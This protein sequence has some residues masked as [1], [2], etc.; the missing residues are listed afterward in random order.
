MDIKE[1]LI[2][3]EI[4]S[5]PNSKLAQAYRMGRRDVHEEYNKLLKD[6]PQDTLTLEGVR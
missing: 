5:Y 4:R 3:R 2:Y 1:Q 6:N